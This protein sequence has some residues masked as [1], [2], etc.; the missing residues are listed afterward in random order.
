L[1]FFAHFAKHDAASVRA[2][3]HVAERRQWWLSFSG[4]VVTLLLTVGIVSFSLSVYALQFNFLDTSSI[5][6]ATRALVAMVLLFVVYV[7]YQQL[8]IH[9]FRMRLGEREELFRLITENAADMIAVVTADGKRLYNSPSYEK[10]LGYSAQEL[11]ETSAYAQI[12]PDDQPKVTK[13]AE[14]ARSSGVGSRVEYRISP[15]ER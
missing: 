12:H 14:Q 1:T 11:R 6:L 13:A 2:D 15:Q 7:I 8:Q 3:L 4:V 5:H 9:R 10:V